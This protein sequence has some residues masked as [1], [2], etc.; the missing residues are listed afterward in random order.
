M[1]K[2]QLQWTFSNIGELLLSTVGEIYSKLVAISQI[3]KLRPAQMEHACT[4]GR[5]YLSTLISKK[6]SYFLAQPIIFGWRTVHFSKI[7]FDIT[8]TCQEKL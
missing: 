6:F 1:Q 4:G 7:H 5:E 3:S 2:Y 8:V